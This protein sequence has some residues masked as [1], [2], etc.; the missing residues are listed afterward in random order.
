MKKYSNLREVV[1]SPISRCEI[2]SLPYG[3]WHWPI[4][5]LS[6]IIKKKSDHEIVC[7]VFTCYLDNIN[8]EVS[9]VGILE[10]E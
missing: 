10:T 8:P 2:S 3:I 4:G 9:Q 6:K 5:L 1:D 7:N